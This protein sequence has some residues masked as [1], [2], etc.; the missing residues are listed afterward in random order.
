MDG[1]DRLAQEKLGEPRLTHWR[2]VVL[3]KR[4]DRSHLGGSQVQ[5]IPPPMADRPNSVGRLMNVDGDNLRR[6]HIPGRG[7]LMSAM[8]LGVVN[9]DEIDGG[10]RAGADPLNRT[11]MPVQ[12][13]HANGPPHGLPLDLVANGHAARGDRAGHDRSVPR[14]GERAVDRHPK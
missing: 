13:A 10:P 8:N 14:H 7:E 4:K 6:P 5:R 9:P 11:V 2:F 12:P 1:N 3:E